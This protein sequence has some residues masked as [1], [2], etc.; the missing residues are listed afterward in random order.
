LLIA[1]L[2]HESAQEYV[3]VARSRGLT[4]ARLF[5]RHL[6]KPSMLPR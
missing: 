6:V 3:L 1:N 5:M 4:R 2:D